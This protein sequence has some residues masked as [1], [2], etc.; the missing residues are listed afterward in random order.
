MLSLNTSAESLIDQ[1]PGNPDTT[2]VMPSRAA[3]R[4][5]RPVLCQHADLGAVDSFEQWISNRQKDV[6]LE[7]LAGLWVHCEMS[8]IK[9]LPCRFT[10]WADDRTTRSPFQL[11][12]DFARL[13]VSRRW[14][15]WVIRKS[16][17]LSG[18]IQVK[19]LK[20]LGNTLMFIFFF[21]VALGVWMTL[22][23]ARQPLINGLSGWGIA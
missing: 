12:V 18:R 13:I 8:F 1:I 14:S 17:T 15:T 2:H 10:R 7:Q 9:E 23:A 4:I 19:L 21:W 20:G 11:G 5:F 16:G 22:G 6:S 3:M